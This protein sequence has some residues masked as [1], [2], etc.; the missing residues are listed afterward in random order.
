MEENTMTNNQSPGTTGEGAKTFTQ[1]DVNRIIGERLAKEKAANDAKLA[2]REQELTHREMLLTAKEKITAA[3]LPTELTEAINMTN[4]ETVDKA[5][6]IIQKIIN[7]KE[8]ARQQEAKIPR[9]STGT[10][11]QSEARTTSSVIRNAMGLNR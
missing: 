8:E 9:F 4:A 11:I 2:Q 6:E 1:E 5:L 10:G 7:D 3:G